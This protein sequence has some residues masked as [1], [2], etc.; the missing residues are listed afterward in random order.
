[1]K[2][3]ELV[4]GLLGKKNLTPANAGESEV[5]M[6][7]TSTTATPPAASGGITSAEV[8]A[9]VAKA[10]GPVADVLKGLGDSHKALSDT[11]GKIGTPDAIAKVVTD[12]LAAQS[13]ASADAGAAKATKD[14]ARQKVVDSLLKG[15]PANLI[16][17]PDTADEAFLTAAAKELR[18]AIGALPGVK[19]PDVA[20]ATADG[21]TTPAAAKPGDTAQKFTQ[22]NTGLDP[23]MA[24]YASAVDAEITALQ[25]K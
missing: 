4:K 18:T 10:L 25:G 3:V 17:L 19:L 12:T 8:E 22:A 15:V 5:A 20:G 23:G 13:K 11:V 1:M 14:A 21:G 16:N 6:G 9:I 24:K 2:I 7:D